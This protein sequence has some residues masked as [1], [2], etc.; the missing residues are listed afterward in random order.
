MVETTKARGRIRGDLR[1]FFFSARSRH[2]K[3]EKVAQIARPEA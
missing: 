3:A 1:A 2:K